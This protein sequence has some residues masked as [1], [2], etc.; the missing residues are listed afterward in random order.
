MKRLVF[1]LLAITASITSAFAAEDVRAAQS[2][3]KQEGFYLGELNGIYDSETAAAVSRY[4]IR[5]GLEISGQLDGKTAKALGLK[6]AKGDAK[7]SESGS[8]AWRHLR[9]PDRQYLA[10]VDSSKVS[11][12]SATPSGP[13]PPADG[14]YQMLGL[15][16]E[17]LRDYVGAFVL[18]GLDPEVG[19]EI[20]FF[21]D[22]VKYYEDGI[23]DREKIRRDLQRYNKRWPERHFWLHGEIDVQP[24]A[25]SSLRVSFP[26]RFELRNGSRR[27]SGKVQKEL[28]LEVTGEDLQIIGVSERKIK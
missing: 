26:L 24:Q 14:E 19:A 6:G 12:L 1:L 28:L 5:N 8:E 22:R 25:D 27:S 2:R 3:L 17:R 9:K 16:R 11:T 10:K 15:S 4:Q 21:A 23:L 7:A 20:E 13:K 18:A